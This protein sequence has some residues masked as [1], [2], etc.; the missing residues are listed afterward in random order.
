M[1]SRAALLAEIAAETR[2]TARWTG[3]DA[4]SPRVAAAIAKVRRAA[5]VPT[6]SMEAAYDNRPLPIG[7]G[8]TIS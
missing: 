2:E 7:H 8:Q 3:R 1:D 6:A 4:L 5:F